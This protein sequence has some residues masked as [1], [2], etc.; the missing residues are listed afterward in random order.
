MSL[1]A[2]MCVRPAA[3]CAREGE[4]RPHAAVVSVVMPGS[5]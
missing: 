3:V 4:S 1:G 2:V 5:C